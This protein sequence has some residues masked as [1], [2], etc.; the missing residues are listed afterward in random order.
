[1]FCTNCG[2]ENQDSNKFCFN[3][4]TQIRHVT[5]K[6]NISSQQQDSNSKNHDS[7]SVDINFAFYDNDI[8]IKEGTDLYRNKYW[9]L[10]NDL[11]SIS[12]AASIFS[13]SLKIPIE[14]IMG[15]EHIKSSNNK[16]DVL[17]SLSD[18]S[19]LLIEM[20]SLAYKAFNNNFN[21]K[22][23]NPK[24][25][26]L[27][28][29]ARKEATLMNRSALIAAPIIIGL[30]IFGSLDKKE[31]T[32][33]ER[34]ANPSHISEDVQV[35]EAQADA[36]KKIIRANGYSCNTLSSASWFSYSSKYSVYCNNWRYSYEI[37]DVGGNW[38]VSVN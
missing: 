38:V 33:K 9:K 15:I 18:N 32:S 6:V 11:S 13:Y 21:A 17:L 24:Y 10:S 19:T 35:T 22:G 28:N 26:T 25:I 16:D 3:C 23:N 37:D 27:P 34:Q 7:S 4:G 30:A 31:D 1:M 5:L 8:K 29:E 20:D 14:E 36:I 2:K 12:S